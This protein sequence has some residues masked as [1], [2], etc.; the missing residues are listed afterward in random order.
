[1]NTRRPVGRLRRYREYIGRQQGLG[2]NLLVIGVLVAFGSAVGAYFLSHQ[3]FNPPWE[4]RYTVY[5]TFEESPAIS[6]GNGQEVRIAGVIAGDIRSADVSDEG[7][8]VLELRIE[9]EYAVYDNARVVLRSKSPLNEMYIELHPG[10]PPGTELTDGDTLPAA[11]SQRPIQVDQFLGHLDDNTRVALTS[12]LAEADVALAGAPDHL[13]AGLRE[14]DATLGDLQPVVAE[15]ET[16]RSTLAELVTALS[17]ISTAVGANDERL[18]HLADSLQRTLG[19]VG[20]SS[21]ELDAALAQLPEFADR[22]RAATDGVSE[23]ATELDPTL[24]E[25]RAASGE[26]PGALSRFTD[27]VDELDSTLD[28]LRPVVQKAT[29]VVADLRPA[30]HDLNLMLDDLSPITQRL[31]PVTSGLL[32]YLTDLQAFVYNTNSTFSLTDANR[33]ILRGQVNVTP[34]SI[35]Q[36]PDVAAATGGDDE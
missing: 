8:A 7:Q 13:P 34:Q 32:P 11:N 29:P 14:L 12:L 26:L 20:G 5:A 31:D 1:M 9:D 36:L 16:R 21:A 17:R 22:L 25:L 27:S 10:G 4:D 6:P 15:L 2:R 18:S 33:G 23:L 28:V 24:D 19:T 30:V 3:R 35:P